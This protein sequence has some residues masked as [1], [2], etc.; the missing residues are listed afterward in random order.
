MACLMKQRRLDWLTPAN[1]NHLSQVGKVNLFRI[2]KSET[3]FPTLCVR[4]LLYEC[5]ST[6]SP[7]GLSDDQ[8]HLSQVGKVN[9]FRMFK[10]QTTFL[11]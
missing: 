4:F 8:S 3:T 1:Q 10:V 11:G 9:L 6:D 2:C 5:S 7:D